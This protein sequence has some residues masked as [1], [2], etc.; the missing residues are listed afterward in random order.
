[1]KILIGAYVNFLGP[2]QIAEKILFW[3]DKYE[4]DRVYGFGTWLAT[5]KNG[6]DSWLM[7]TCRWIHSKQKR[8]VKVKIHNYDTWDVDSTLN[9]IIHPLLVEF[10]KNV[11]STASVDKEDV[12]EELHS[13]YGEYSESD[14]G[15]NANFSHEAWLYV[16]NEMIWAF[17]PEWDDKYGF[18]AAGYSYEEYKKAADR[19]QK[20]YELFGKYLTRIWN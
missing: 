7:K 2:Y 8:K 17:D 5:D 19:Q 10:V 4:D 9:L 15:M 3:L 1:M 11:H 14:G 18:R 16:L 13:T 12:A 6:N 20:S